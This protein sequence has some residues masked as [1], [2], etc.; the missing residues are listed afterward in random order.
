ME[1]GCVIN[2]KSKI[3]KW[4][5]SKEAI[6]KLYPLLYQTK[7]NAGKLFIDKSGKQTLH[8]VTVVEGDKDSVEAPLSIINYHTH[9]LFC[10]NAENTIL[11]FL[12]GEDIRESILF[13]LKGSITH[14]VPACEGLYV[15]QVNPCILENLIHLED[16][17]KL[18][19]E[20]I[21]LLRK[22]KVK[23]PVNFFR[24][25]LITC[26]EIY[27]RGAHAYRTYDFV[28]KYKITG[29]DYV[30]YINSFNIKK[31]FTKGVLIHEQME[32]ER[33]PFH[34]Y[35]TDFE[36]NALVYICDKNGN[37][38][39][40][41]IKFSFVLKNNLLKY[42]KNLK[43]GESCKYTKKLWS[44]RWFLMKLYHNE[45]IYNG[46]RKDYSKFSADE[47]RDFISRYSGKL[48]SNCIT[49]VDSPMFYFFDMKG[50]CD[51]QQIKSNLKKDKC[52]FGEL[53]LRKG[54]GNE[55]K[56]FGAEDC[57]WCHKALDKLKQLQKD[58]KKFTLEVNMYPDIRTAIHHV[59]KIDKKFDSIPVI[60]V[61]GKHID[62]GDLYSE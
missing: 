48:G 39:Y 35:G 15:C 14:I 26:I 17:L 33:V 7:E 24:G 23:D 37:A 3:H 30:S 28:K 32:C 50:N 13:S 51:V 53:L 16:Y 43:L 45:I 55:I 47:Q 44:E 10:Y 56:L 18:D 41:N 34:Q 11:G 40:S 49:L 31:M 22:N 62:N 19:D 4:K 6:A 61:N 58:G 2:Y 42:I 25:L 21:S 1:N 46:V 12:S 54:S 60:L 36:S 8:D 27:F 57:M 59:K 9:P 20:V 52:K 29:D 5:I 38:N